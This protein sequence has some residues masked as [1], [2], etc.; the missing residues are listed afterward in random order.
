MPLG[1]KLLVAFSAAVC[2]AAALSALAL[3]GLD[4]PRYLVITDSLGSAAAIAVA[5]VITSF[6]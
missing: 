5:T 1:F 2:V 6:A 3:D 4:L